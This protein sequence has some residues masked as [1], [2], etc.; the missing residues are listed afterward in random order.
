MVCAQLV[1]FGRVSKRREEKKERASRR[2][3]RP[4]LDPTRTGSSMDGMEIT[5]G[6]AQ[7]NMV[8]DN[9]PL[10]NTLEATMIKRANGACKEPDEID[11]DESDGSYIESTDS[12][13][14]L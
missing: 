11:F 10:I 14:I 2:K 1:A 13:I 5:N 9:S 4:G 7:L 8:A 3:E 6:P 12:E